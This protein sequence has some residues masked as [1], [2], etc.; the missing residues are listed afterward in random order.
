MKS[1]KRLAVLACAGAFV[2]GALS[3][4][5]AAAKAEGTGTLQGDGKAMVMFVMTASNVY[6]AN[7]I[8]GAKQEAERLGWDLTVFQHN[9]SQPEQ[10]AQVQQYIASGA[11]P[12]GDHLLAVGRRCGDQRRAP[13][14]APCT[15][16]PAHAGA[17]RAVLALRPGI[18][19]RQSDS[20]RRDARPH[21]AAGA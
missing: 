21:D 11:E 17:E 14:C 3:A 7:Q 4:P 6:G 1:L 19:R 2:A 20:D 8:K 12:E 15:G 9:F 18:L 10:D 13:A 16:H 5:W